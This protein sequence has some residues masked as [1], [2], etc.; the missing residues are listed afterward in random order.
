MSTRTS[1]SPEE[2][3]KAVEN[4][5]AV[6][7]Q[8]IMM[9]RKCL[10]TRNHFM[11]ALKHASTFLN[12]LRNNSL[13][14]KEYYELYIMVYDG[15]EYLSE[16]LRDT[17]PDNHLADLYELVQYAGNIIPRLYLMITVGSVYMGVKDA[18][19]KEIMNDMLEMCR[20]VQHPIRGLF[21]RYYLSQRTKDLLPTNGLEEQ[22]VQGGK[23]EAQNEANSDKEAEQTK[24]AGAQSSL[25][26]DVNDSIRFIITNF[27]EMNKL[28][29]RWQHQGHSSEFEKRTE[30]RKELQVLVGSNLVRM[31]QLEA[32]KRVYYKK[33]ILPLILEQI[34]KCRDVIAQEYLL[35]VIIQ[36]FPDEFHLITMDELFSATLRLDPAVSTKKIILSLVERL[37]AF[38]KREPE[39][40]SKVVSEDSVD[41]FGKF[42]D[43]IDKLLQWKPDLSTQDYCK[44]LC[45]MCQLSVIYYPQKYENID[46][47]FEHAVKFYTESQKIEKLKD[48]KTEAKVK[49]KSDEVTPPQTCWKELLTCPVYQYSDVTKVLELG[50]SYVKFVNEMSYEL[51]KTVCR[52]IITQ[53]LKEK[54]QITTEEGLK[55]A[56]SLIDPF[57]RIQD[58]DE[59]KKTAAQ[60]TNKQL[61]TPGDIISGSSG[62]TAADLTENAEQ[63]PNDNIEIQKNEELLAK[64]IHTI[65]NKNPYKYFALLEVARSELAKS[66]LRVKYTYPTLVSMTLKLIRKLHLVK[67]LK[68]ERQ[69][70]KVNRFFTFISSI[71]S[72][73]SKHNYNAIDCFNMDLTTAE[74]ADEIGMADISYDFFIESLVIYEQFFLDSRSQYHA[75]MGL[76]NK[77]I[78]ARSLMKTDNFDRLITRTTIY[79]SKLLRKTDQCRAIYMASHLWWIVDDTEKDG[80]AE[81]AEVSD[82]VNGVGH[83][84]LKSDG[85][86]VL[87]CLQRALRTA[88]SIL[89]S[90]VSLELFIE[91]LN[92]SLY[93]FI[94]G[95]ILITVRYLNGL[96][97]LIEN[98]FTSLGKIEGPSLLTWN[99]FQRTLKYISEQKAIDSRFDEVHA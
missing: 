71:L 49:A 65:Y 89:D 30:E 41:I 55:K 88:D 18:P 82:L 21:L 6:I 14:P 43:F 58:D 33:N 37:I 90:N 97:E 50:E 27:I 24:P 62:P 29:V 20:G 80:E 57:I 23:T 22:D 84:S 25:H 47:V 92:Q 86:R 48:G 2:Q 15:L 75:L 83:L 76:I 93:F 54:A 61:Q 34:I 87:E 68:T 78:G 94:H 1:A 96:I 16:Y 11:D 66:E 42:I 19:I 7:R 39:Y 31:S 10:E 69:K 17:H 45:G 59:S 53:F 8:H 74:I 3:A 40:V 52:E 44:L 91:I 67:H 9:M 98:N 99:H 56:F 38:K 46:S 35:D 70:K 81:N 13:S 64:F 4:S 12:E 51:R 32:I 73:L 72:E 36:V 85:K 26:G 95:N 79:S 5:A 60:K 28:W 63:A 77:L